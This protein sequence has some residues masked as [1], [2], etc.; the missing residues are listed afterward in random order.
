MITIFDQE[1][2]RVGTITQYTSAQWIKKFYDT[3]SFEIH[4]PNTAA[5]VNFLEI[6]NVIHANDNWGFILKRQWTQNEVVIYGYDL[7][8]ILEYRAVED[9]NCSMKTLVA[10]N[11]D[12]DAPEHF[13]GEI[14]KD[15]YRD[16]KLEIAAN[17]IRK[18]AAEDEIGY[19]VYIN[20]AGEIERE[21]KKGA[22][23]EYLVFSADRR[24]ISEFMYEEDRYKACTTCVYLYQGETTLNKRSHQLDNTLYSEFERQEI[25]YN[26]EIFDNPTTLDLYDFQEQKLEEKIK[27]NK[28]ISEN[29]SF[30]PGKY[31]YKKDYFL[32]DYV[33]VKI[34]VFGKVLC[35]KK[36]ITEVREVFEST[37]H[38]VEITV[39][40]TKPNYIR[41]LKNK[42]VI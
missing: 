16:P 40:T 28:S 19:D 12:I 37:G 20:S 26:D 10:Y 15:V 38:T 8:G 25:G 27:E 13:T 3:G 31:V 18:I 30:M 24:N 29:I 17:L 42:G 34:E 14:S 33:T 35:E 1:L 4:I 36:Q 32:G 11:D 41:V 7:C 23:R 39:G 6:Y 21:I 22:N 2:K 9:L 5:G